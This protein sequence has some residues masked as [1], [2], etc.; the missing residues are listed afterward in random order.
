VIACGKCKQG[1]SAVA[2][3]KFSAR[4]CERKQILLA[5]HRPQYPTAA[6]MPEQLDVELIWWSIDARRGIQSAIL[7]LARCQTNAL[8]AGDN[9]ERFSELS[10]IAFSLWRAAFLSSMGSRPRLGERTSSD[11]PQNGG[12]EVSSSQTDHAAELL[13]VIV[14][15]NAVGF[16]D[17]RRTQYWMGQYYIDNAGY[18]AD[19]YI[20]RWGPQTEPAYFQRFRELWHEKQVPAD[21]AAS[22][23]AWMIIYAP[24]V[25]L[26]LQFM[27]EVGIKPVS[28]FQRLE[29]SAYK[30][31]PRPASLGDF[32]TDSNPQG[33]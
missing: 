10:G 4:S 24:F 21:F 2:T 3:P 20:E 13:R 23:A 31:I 33:L 30:F 18:R 32:F 26:L 6:L 16:A 14:A 12:K 17:D 9:A 28:E 22:A 19:H 1:V 8:R 5:M 15:S 11:V 25:D 27:S 7:N 29:T